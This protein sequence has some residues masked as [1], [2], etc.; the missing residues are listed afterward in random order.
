M[1]NVHNFPNPNRA[2]DEASEWLAK[3]DRG[4]SD[5]EEQALDQWLHASA[6]NPSALMQ[7]AE[8]WDRMDAL[9]GVSAR[10]P[11]PSELPAQNKPVDMRFASAAMVVLA[12]TLGMI[13]FGEQPG[14]VP[15][16][17]AGEL[18]EVEPRIYQTGT[19]EQSSVTLSDGSVLTLN[20]DTRLAISFSAQARNITLYRG[21]VHIQVAH[22]KQRPLTAYAGD[23]FVES[24]GTA[25]NLEITDRQQ[26][27]LIVTEGKVLVAARAPQ[28]QNW[29][30]LPP[31][32]PADAAVAEPE[33]LVAGESIVLGGEQE[34]VEQ[35]EPEE[36]EV[37]L[38]WQQGNLVFR[39]ESL[40]EAISEIQRYTTVEFVILD[41]ALKTVRVAGLFRAGD[42]D[43]LLST[44]RDNFNVTHRKAG[45]EKI[46]LSALQSQADSLVQRSNRD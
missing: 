6:D 18:V 3:I 7:V 26:V 13:Y 5:A 20:T 33:Y 11:Q 17:A 19:G 31:A 30:D 22:D 24:V 43:G 14:D 32:A 29:V 8:L 41:D 40:E 46:L 37:K 27:E 34:S 44:L 36:I 15:G 9:A 12:L 4:L 21:E 45:E 23:R 35:L 16:G 2:L 39:G 42:V 38:S 1:S 25:F 10:F 28:A